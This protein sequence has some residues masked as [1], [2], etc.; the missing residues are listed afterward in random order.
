M[1]SMTT[2]TLVDEMIVSINQ[3]NIA[4]IRQWSVIEEIT[5]RTSRPD[6]AICYGRLLGVPTTWTDRRAKCAQLLIDT[7]N[8]SVKVS[9]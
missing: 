2:A 7:L 3:G 5:K 4:G 6:V 8:H 9:K 1:E